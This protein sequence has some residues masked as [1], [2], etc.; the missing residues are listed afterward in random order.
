M[1][2]RVIKVQ[3]ADPGRIRRYRL[4]DRGVEKADCDSN[5]VTAT[6]YVSSLT[7]EFRPW[8]GE[9]ATKGFQGVSLP[10]KVSVGI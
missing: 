9:R 6:G 10:S 4:E 2:S 8:R 1:R 7:R 3:I 5:R